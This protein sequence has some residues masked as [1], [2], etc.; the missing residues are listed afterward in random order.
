[1]TVEELRKEAKAMGYNIIRIAPKEKLLPCVCGCKRREH[2]VR[3]VR[4][5]TYRI[6]GCK[7]CEREAMGRTDRE[8]RH[9]WNEMIRGESGCDMRGDE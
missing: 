5:D 3:F 2:W 6:I 4:G 8:V 7:K 1:M 9:N